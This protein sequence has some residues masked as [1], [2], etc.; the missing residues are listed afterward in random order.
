[1]IVPQTEIIYHDN[2]ELSAMDIMLQTSQLTFMDTL[3]IRL[4]KHEDFA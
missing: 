4:N 1:M 3:L 2:G